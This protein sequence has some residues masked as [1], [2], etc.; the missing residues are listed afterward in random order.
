MTKKDMKETKDQKV[1]I[2]QHNRT[3]QFS[4]AAEKNTSLFKGIM[5]FLALIIALAAFLALVY[6]DAYWAKSFPHK[7][8]RLIET[9]IC[10]TLAV[11]AFA[12]IAVSSG[13]A[14]LAMVDK[15]SAETRSMYKD[16]VLDNTDFR[17]DIDAKITT[18]V[19]YAAKEL[20]GLLTT[21]AFA[22]IVISTAMTLF[23]H[24]GNGQFCNEFINNGNLCGFA[25][26]HTL[27]IVGINLTVVLLTIVPV[28]TVTADLTEIN[29]NSSNLPG[30]VNHAWEFNTTFA[31][32]L[33]LLQM[34][35]KEVKTDGTK[36][37]A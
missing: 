2:Q 33:A 22:G 34:P 29:F 11:V 35:P 24:Y 5:I 25:T 30:S 10:L 13:K 15:I 36:D 17:H 28:V 16:W 20:T 7:D 14:Y 37:N 1:L 19:Q 23:E 27:V 3:M 31:D 21:L 32:R 9:F 6:G 4:Q 12:I 26:V 8:Y 18:L